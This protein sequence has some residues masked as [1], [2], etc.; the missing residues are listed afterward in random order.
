[1][2][3]VL[4][5][6]ALAVVLIGGVMY[7]ST[8]A[9]EGHGWSVP[10][11][12]ATEAT[13]VG[14]ADEPAST[15]SDERAKPSNNDRVS[16]EWS[17]AVSARTGIP[18]RAVRA[19]AGAAR[20][21]AAT[22]PACHLGWT[23]IA[24]LGE[25]ESHH[26][27]FGGSRLGADGVVRPGILG[28]RLNGDGYDAVT[29]TDGGVLD[30]D[31]RHDRAVGPLQFLPSSWATWGA[32]GNGDRVAD[33]QQLDDAALAAAGY[34]CHSGDL[35]MAERWRAAIYSYNHLDSYVERVAATANAYAR[36]AS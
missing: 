29:D 4:W 8:P 35:S 6:V 25:I 2:R 31:V 30:G 15:T 10:L 28:P 13:P 24:A 36:E 5:G 33:P 26:G 3:R 1:M 17:S 23:T 20:A 19:Y 27:A 22:T 18:V 9:A 34:L 21:A 16:A 14:P 12:E 32:D 7:A 11:A